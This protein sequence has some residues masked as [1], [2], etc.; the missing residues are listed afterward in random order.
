MLEG[1]A[2]GRERGLFYTMESV[3]LH[4]AEKKVE[5]T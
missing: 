4:S 5:Y 3:F 1:K 2:D